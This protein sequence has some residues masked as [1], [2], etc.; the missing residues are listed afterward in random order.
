MDEL[1]PPPPVLTASII[2][3]RSLGPFALGASTHEVLSLVRQDSKLY[4]VIDLHH[5]QSEPLSTPV[6]I[7]LPENGIRLRFDGADQ[8]LR[9][10]EV[11]DYSKLRLLYKGSEL[12]KTSEGAMPTSGP[13]FMRVY[14][15]LGP[16]YPGEYIAPKDRATAGTY[17]L[18][19]EGV[20][21]NF[22]L[23][24]S[25]WMSSKDKEHVKL[26][27]SASA[28]VATN[29]ALF[30]GKSWPDARR[31]LFTA[32]PNGPRLSAL[33][34]RPKDN[35]P[36]E[37]D[38]AYVAGDGRVTLM[39]APSAGDFTITIN[40]TTAQDLVTELG[41]PDAMHRR[42][43]HEVTPE[44]AVHRRTG[45][46]SRPL[47]NGRS[48]PGSQPSSY[49]STGT[50]TFETEFESGDGEDDAFDRSSRQKFWCYFSHGV[51]I[52]IGPPAEP[53][54]AHPDHAPLALNPHLVVLKVVIHGNV[55]GSYAFARHRRLRWTICVPPAQPQGESALF[56]SEQHFENEIRPALLDTYASVWPASEMKK[57]K[58]VN[59]TWGGDINSAESSFVMPNI[60]GD[61][62][63]MDRVDD[64]GRSEQWLGNTRLYAFP[65]LTFEVLENGAVAGLTVSL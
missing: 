63:G 48:H 4:S 56:T 35:L 27:D 49:S 29:M 24:H 17:V 57:G 13:S 20:A 10:I 21:F 55:P 44:P 58:V 16:S 45:S 8:R 23:Q 1:H 41:S 3:G 15:L 19:W 14:R 33:A 43:E 47:S 51:D 60:A 7:T 30:E 61:M 64:V 34:S 62:D 37:I 50:D 12:I 31:D 52:L 53:P 2:P 5:S 28:S 32:P 25:A 22:G 18:S 39:R 46:T 59:R 9:L 40:E 38:H 26:L 6:I 54:I 65:G 11:L 42:Q 36:P